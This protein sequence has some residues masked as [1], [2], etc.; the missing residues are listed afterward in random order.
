MEFRNLTPFP[1][2]AFE[3]VDQYDE[4]FH[5]IVLRQTLDFSSGKLEYADVQSPLCE[6]DT[7]FGE[8]NNSSV[9]QESDLCHYKPRCDVLLNG[10]AHAPD[11]LAVKRLRVRL[12]VM[13]ADTPAS[14]PER[15]LGLNPFQEPSVERIEEWR[16]ATERARSTINRGRTL[17]DKTLWVMGERKFVSYSLPAR[18]LLR[19]IGW[20]T[21]GM[22]KPNPWRLTG[23]IRFLSLPIRYEYA[24]GGQCR[25]NSKD[26]AAKRVPKKYRLTQAQQAANQGVHVLGAV[27]TVAHQVWERNIV[28]RGFAPDW[29]V[30]A[31]RIRHLLAPRIELDTAPL[32]RQHFWRAL[33][34]KFAN[35]N[36][37][38]AALEPAGFGVRAKSHPARRSL[39]GTVDDEFIEGNAWLPADF[40]FAVWNAAPFDQQIAHLV[41]DETVELTNLCASNAPGAKP[42]DDGN[43][44][45]CLHLLRHECFA[46]LRMG[47]GELLRHRLKIDTLLI[48][49]DEQKLTLVWR[50]RIPKNL[51]TP[52][53]VCEA[54]MQTHSDRDDL[55]KELA[56]VEAVVH[57]AAMQRNAMSIV[58]SSRQMSEVDL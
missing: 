30:R 21:L 48:E 56:H 52:I 57:R 27:Q 12:R 24:F 45:L 6:I 11:A 34:G 2:L 35:S 17:L 20:G 14:L 15:P 58:N 29:Y 43:T 32:R 10:S 22:F 5:V 18:V 9:K 39:L 42:D 44:K 46:L 38:P 41:N 25:I 13:A 47:T 37:I 54:R 33:R 55:E 36:A 19:M 4:K 40:N 23:A 28:G 3:G 50:A 7:F 31:C 1:A 49:P 16:Q 51:D 8:M 53:R 26:K